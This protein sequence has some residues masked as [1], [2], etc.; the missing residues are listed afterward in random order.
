MGFG[1]VGP[2][3][4]DQGDVKLVVAANVTG[5]AHIGNSVSLGGLGLALRATYDLDR[6]FAHFDDYELGL[7][8]PFV[9]CRRGRAIVQ[10]GAE[11]QRANLHK[12]LYYMA[13]GL[14]F[15]RRNKPAAEPPRAAQSVASTN[16]V[17]GH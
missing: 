11:I 1:M 4:Y 15:G 5:L 7:G 3:Q 10:I 2:A 12:N 16:Q 13:V 14:G 8:V 6:L 17:D 9:T